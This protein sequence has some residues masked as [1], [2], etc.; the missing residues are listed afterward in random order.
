MCR[1]LPPWVLAQ[2]RRTTSFHP[3][4]RVC[5]CNGI[6]TASPLSP[7]PQAASRPPLASSP[8]PCQPGR[9]SGCRSGWAPRLHPASRRPGHPCC[10]WG[11]EPDCITARP[12]RVGTAAPGG[13]GRQNPVHQH[14]LRS[15]GPPA[16]RGLGGWFRAPV[17][18]FPCLSRGAGRSLTRGFNVAT[19]RLGLG[20]HTGVVAV[21]LAVDVACCPRDVLAGSL[22]AG[23]LGL[24][25]APCVRGEAQA[26]LVRFL[27]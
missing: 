1:R 24:S 15:A 25:V 26:H 17:A 12:S 21:S 20:V 10:L 5:L 2:T 14:P 11:C 4:R 18:S 9:V 27:L 19:A 22:L 16:P 13:C 23:A 6:R 7:S 8:A 3:K